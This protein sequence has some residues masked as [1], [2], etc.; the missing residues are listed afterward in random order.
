M[1]VFKTPFP[2]SNPNPHTPIKHDPPDEANPHL[3]SPP[4]ASTTPIT[5]GK[6]SGSRLTDRDIFKPSN[7]R[8]IFTETFTL[9]T[10]IPNTEEEVLQKQRSICNLL[11]KIKKNTDFL[12]SET[13]GNKKIHARIYCMLGD[14]RLNCNNLSKEEISEAWGFLKKA[15][16]LGDDSQGSANYL[17]GK[18]LLKKCAHLIKETPPSPDKIRIHF[19]QANAYLTEANNISPN[20]IGAHIYMTFARGNLKKV[21]INKAYKLATGCINNKSNDGK[22]YLLKLKIYG[23]PIPGVT[24]ENIEEDLEKLTHALPE[25]NYKKHKCNAY[26]GIMLVDNYL[27]IIK[28]LTLKDIFNSKKVRYI[29]TRAHS[30]LTLGKMAN[31]SKVWEYLHISEYYLR[32]I[33]K[34]IDN[35]CNTLYLRIKN[36]NGKLDSN[37]IKKE[38]RQTCSDI[39]ALF[40]AMKRGDLVAVRHD[41]IGICYYV[42]T[43]LIQAINSC[44]YDAF[45]NLIQIGA[46]PL[47]IMQC[48]EA[49]I[50]DDNYYDDISHKT[51]YKDIEKM[52]DTSIFC[53]LTEMINK[54]AASK[55]RDKNLKHNKYMKMKTIV[56]KTM[57]NT[58]P[59]ILKNPEGGETLGLIPHW[60]IDHACNMSAV[61][62]DNGFDDDLFNE[63]LECDITNINVKD[64]EG[65]TILMFVCTRLCY[66]LTLFPPTTPINES[67]I[68]DVLP[69]IAKPY[70]RIFE[71][72]L[73][74]T[75]YTE[76]KKLDINAKDD[77]GNT[78]M[79]RVTDHRHPVQIPLRERSQYSKKV[80]SE[81]CETYTEFQSC[82]VRM[83][84]HSGATEYISA[85]EG[86][87]SKK[88]KKT[89]LQFS[90]GTREEDLD[91][92]NK[93]KKLRFSLTPS[94][95]E[96]KYAFSDLRS[97]SS[98]GEGNTD[99]KEYS[100]YCQLATSI[101]SGKTPRHSYTKEKIYYPSPFAVHTTDDF[102][103]ISLK[104]TTL[105]GI[106][107]TGFDFRGAEYLSGNVFHGARYLGNRCLSALFKDDLSVSILPNS[108]SPPAIILSSKGY[109]DF[110]PSEEYLHAAFAHSNSGSYEKVAFYA[111]LRPDML[112]GTLEESGF[113]A[114]R[115]AA[116][117][118]DFNFVNLVLHTQPAILAST[119]EDGYTPLM[120]FIKS[121]TKA[122]CACENGIKSL[123]RYMRYTAYSAELY[124]VA[125]NAT[126]NA[127]LVELTQTKDGLTVKDVI[128]TC[129]PDMQKLCMQILEQNAKNTQLPLPL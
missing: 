87:G 13:P 75:S 18:H 68:K 56:M 32:N 110:N 30:Y 115:E 49:F 44:N 100:A 31:T 14:L 105:R 106:N 53:Y 72:L 81:I 90:G 63:I 70:Y 126:Q 89:P 46:D 36:D 121:A 95:L 94:Q 91:G 79:S 1:C 41:N 50:E 101:A 47:E 54:N 129:S 109:D 123:I 69:D 66:L 10:K 12:G 24:F 67:N 22:Y 7:T 8:E 93:Y 116:R 104:E 34:W 117:S 111:L 82:L 128:E 122:D 9:Y 11:S 45:N 108:M 73:K 99:F 39:N 51:G 62:G 42:P 4:L 125:N 92:G 16:Q 86:N 88:I 71:K 29:I 113:N 38:L 5:L 20:H 120:L 26:I 84:K 19:E 52:A 77:Y 15:V 74:R 37:S 65:T 21:N 124:D 40:P 57:K 17:L 61:F 59:A 102:V 43:L 97:I 112:N 78:A 33:D 58:K 27:K 6:N 28:E 76:E 103:G 60:Y 23:F 119:D 107:L 3:V 118:G 25:D 83:L 55:H 80:Y 127:L 98:L 48:R 96:E 85:T 2:P 64:H 35:F 114:L